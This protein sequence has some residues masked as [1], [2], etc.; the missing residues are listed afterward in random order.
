M[1]GFLKNPEGNRK[2]YYRTLDPFDEVQKAPLTNLCKSEWGQ[3]HLAT[4]TNSSSFKLYL[5]LA[6][7]SYAKI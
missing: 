5:Y 6:T 1:K 3:A 4:P 2:N 7:I